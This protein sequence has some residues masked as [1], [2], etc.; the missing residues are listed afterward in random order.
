MERDRATDQLTDE[1]PAEGDSSITPK[2]SGLQE[3][4]YGQILKSAQ[5]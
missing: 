2:T 1:Q 5:T 4:K 3:Y